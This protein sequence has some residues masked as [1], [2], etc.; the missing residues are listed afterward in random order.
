MTATSQAAAYCGVY[1]VTV[2]TLIK[3]ARG[4]PRRCKTFLSQCSGDYRY[5]I[6][7]RHRMPA[8]PDSEFLTN[9]SFPLPYRVLF[10][11]GLGILAWATNLHGLNSCGVDVIGAMNLRAEANFSKPSIPTYHPAFNHLKIV[12]LYRSTYR[13]F[14]SYTSICILLGSSSGS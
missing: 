12:S 6:Y 11:I 8:P 13:L 4:Q 10:L 5:H 7:Q 1:H 9:I 2:G 3:N 14:L